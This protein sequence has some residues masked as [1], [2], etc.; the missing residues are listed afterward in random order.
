MKGL[1]ICIMMWAV[2]F[3][4]FSLSG[5]IKNQEELLQLKKDLEKVWPL[6]QT[7]KIEFELAL[8]QATFLKTK[9]ETT[10]FWDNYEQ[11]VKDNYFKKVIELNIRQGKLLLLLIDRELGKTP[12]EL[13][14]EYR[15]KR[16]ANYWQSFAKLLG[17]NLKEKYNADDFPDIEQEVKH[18]CHVY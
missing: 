12:Y 9:E 1:I 5:Q 4:P 2:S 14:K 18:L 17:A 10:V 6:T 15:T 7:V 8:A 16:R 3:V 11:F 13:I